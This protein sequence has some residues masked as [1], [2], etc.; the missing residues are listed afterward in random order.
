MLQPTSMSL[1]VRSVEWVR[2]E[3]PFGNPLVDEVEHRYYSW[4]APKKG[5]LSLT[6]LPAVGLRQPSSQPPRVHNVACRGHG[7]AEADQAD[8]PAPASR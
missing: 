8:L 4:T 3:V 5:G 2:S 7:M 1:G 6:S